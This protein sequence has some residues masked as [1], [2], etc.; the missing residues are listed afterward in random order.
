M[1]Y[2]LNIENK[3]LWEETNPHAFLTLFRKLN[4]LQGNYTTQQY[5]FQQRVF[6]NL[7]EH[8]FKILQTRHS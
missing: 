7:S 4:N 5:R 1:P 2:G 6:Q 8:N 3:K